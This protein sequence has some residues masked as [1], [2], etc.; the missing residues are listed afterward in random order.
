MTAYVCVKCKTMWEVKNGDDDLEPSGA[1]CQPCL[2]ESLIP[3][4]RR[5]QL[6]EGNFD[7]FGKAMSQCDQILCAYRRICLA[8]G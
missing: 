5:R 2:R 4:Y 3:L 8:C 1:L 6:R 7:C